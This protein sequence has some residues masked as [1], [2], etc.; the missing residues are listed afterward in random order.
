MIRQLL[1]GDDQGVMTSPRLRD[2]RWAHGRLRGPLTWAPPLL[3][4]L[5]ALRYGTGWSAP[6]RLAVTTLVLYAALKATAIL[7]QSP[8]E[9]LRASPAGRLAYLTV[10]PGMTLAPFQARGSPHPD[11]RRWLRR[12]VIGM[13]LG[14]LA[15][16]ALS[17]WAPQLLD[18]LLG[19]AG[20]G[21]LLLT[22]HLGYADV[23][24][25]LLRRAGFPVRR[26]FDD[27]LASRSLT[28]FWSQRWN[29]A[30]VEMDRLLVVPLLRSLGP[31]GSLIGVFVL[32]GLLHELAI[33]FPAG[34]GWGL[35]SCY[36]LLQGVLVALER[37]LVRPQQ[38]PD[39]LARMWT[40]CWV[41][42]PLPLLF[43]TP[44]RQALVVPLFHW[45]HRMLW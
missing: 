20:I 29:L 12:G 23:L 43:H 4:V 25:G 8:G 10:W 32:S 33:S 35:P 18:S 26:L 28:E 19:W 39:T 27:P 40:W 7:R 36:F 6:V 15:M 14:G 9:L 3:V 37:N 45:L 17:R 41:L 34:A 5:A 38:W 21:A 16:L 24:S 31:V 2:G 11:G 13:A 22:I 30:F 44:F 42:A 1:C